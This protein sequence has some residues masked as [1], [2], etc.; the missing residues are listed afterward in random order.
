MTSRRAFLKK[1]LQLST[2]LG[3]ASL[4]PSCATPYTRSQKKKQLFKISL[5]EWSVHK[6]IRKNTGYDPLDHLDF[7]A[8]AKGLGIDAIEYVNTLF[9]KGADPKYVAQVKT[10]TEEE[11]VKGLLIM[12]DREGKLGEATTA[13]RQVTVDN[14][15]KW[16]DA[17][18]TLGCHSIR[19]NASSRGSYDEQMKLAADGLHM[20][21]DEGDKQGLNV[22]VENHGGFSSNGQWLVGV[23]KLVD[24]PRCGILPD[25]GNFMLD[26]NTGEFYDIYK[27]VAEFMPYAKAVSAKSF[28][29][30]TGKGKFITADQR[31]GRE[32]SL[33]YERLLKIVVDAGYNGYI[34]IE[35]EGEKH[36]PKE[37][38]LK[39][40]AVMEAVREKLG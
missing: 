2:G 17:A 35:Y 19:V 18:A 34:G 38:I 30:D 31:K 16:L 10:R 28:D 32:V 29:W 37:G 39:T 40:K 24:H 6:R 7:A 1:S 15:K 26:R 14:H 4:L 25:F 33:D 13:K 8:C 11:G 12:I 21:C 23:M 36:S 27:G 20:L 22:I 3:L 9:E 5:A